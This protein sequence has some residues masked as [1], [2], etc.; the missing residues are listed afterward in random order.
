[1]GDQGPDGGGQPPARAG[2]S[3]AQ[4]TLLTL[5]EL[6]I[7]TRPSREKTEFKT[8]RKNL[9]HPSRKNLIRILHTVYCM[10]KKQGWQPKYPPKK[11]QKNPPKKTQVG[12]F[13]FF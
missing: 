2:T 6:R 13:G 12:F 1:M 8:W 3:P 10:S 7:R 11:T 4:V 9:K 5:P